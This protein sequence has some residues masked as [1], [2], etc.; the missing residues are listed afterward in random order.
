MTEASPH[1]D[2]PTTALPA[3]LPGEGWWALVRYMLVSLVVTT[4]GELLAIGLIV[5]HDLDHLLSAYAD[6]L[7]ELFR[8][9]IE[10]VLWFLVPATAIVIL[11]AIFLL[12]IFRPPEPS[13]RARSLKKSAAL[14]GCAAALIAAGLAWSLFEL[15]AGEEDAIEMGERFLPGFFVLLPMAILVPTW[16]LWG[17]FFWRLSSPCDPLSMDRMMKPLLA[18][19]AIGMV[20]ML[21]IDAIVRRKKDCYCATGSFWGLVLGII[22]ALWLLGPFVVLWLS[23]T[24]RLR[25][26]RHACLACGHARPP[27]PTSAC[28]ECGRGWTNRRRKRP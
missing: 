10:V 24:R 19:T 8:G 1:G 7:R 6:I 27:G 18:N 14:A 3:G 11:Q 20:L 17:R 23:R 2:R 22:T 12:P 16:V 5:D 4:I 13:K 26:R 15:A 28:Q 25:L 9:D 21:P